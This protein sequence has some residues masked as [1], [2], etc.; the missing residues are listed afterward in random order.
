[1]K[2]D[3]NKIHV[4]IKFWMTVTIDDPS[5][6]SGIPHIELFQELNSVR[7]LSWKWLTFIMDRH[8]IDD[9]CLFPSSPSSTFVGRV[10][11]NR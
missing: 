4:M 6:G 8:L 3:K 5:T 2:E 10:Q 7:P 9:Y 11:Y 1:M